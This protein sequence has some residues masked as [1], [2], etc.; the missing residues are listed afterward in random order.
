MSRF[1]RVMDHL[2]CYERIMWE[3]ASEGHWINAYHWANE[4]ENGRSWE[5]IEPK[6]ADLLADVS[7]EHVRALIRERHLALR[8][9]LNA[10]AGR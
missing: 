9:T 1:E 2:G 5:E 4:H 10:E 8:E 7:I 3:T 6:L